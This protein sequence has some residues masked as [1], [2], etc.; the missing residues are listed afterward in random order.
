MSG[1]DQ[2]YTQSEVIAAIEGIKYPGGGTKTGKALLKAKEALFDASARAGVPNI[3]C[4]LTD[5]RSTDNI[6][7]PAQKL[8]DSGVT[9][10]SI[11]MGTN[12]DLEQLREIATDPDSQH[13]FKGEFDALGS[14]VDSVVD[15]G[16]KGMYTVCLELLI[17]IFS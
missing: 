9:V 17:I 12:Y 15:C 14:L 4:M 16:C 11:G 7:A 6:G 5:G 10:I 2:H 13:V 1:F 3:A 8:R